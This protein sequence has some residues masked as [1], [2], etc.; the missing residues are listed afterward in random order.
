MRFHTAWADSGRTLNEGK[1]M[2]RPIMTPPH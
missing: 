2:A 1:A